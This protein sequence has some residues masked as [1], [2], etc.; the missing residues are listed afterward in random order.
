MIFN[1]WGEKEN[2][3]FITDNIVETIEA[4]CQQSGKN[5]WLFGGGKT[6]SMLLEADL[7]DEM[8]I[9]YVPTMLGKGTPLFPAHPQRSKWKLT[10]SKT[11]NNNILEVNYIKE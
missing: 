4:L 5:I 9:F 8:R 10:G 11:Y 6:I 7:V 3:K 1:D 2:I